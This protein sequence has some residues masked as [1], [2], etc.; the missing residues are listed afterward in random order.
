MNIWL[1]VALMGAFHGINPGMGW[2]FAVALGLQDKNSRSLFRAILPLAL[3]HA[4]ALLICLAV[5]SIGQMMIS[6][7]LIRWLAGGILI[8]FGVYRFFRQ[9]HPRWVGMRVGFRDLSV[10]SFTMALAHGAGLMLIPVFLVG[11]DHSTMHSAH[12]DT[13]MFF[14]W[15]E[16]LMGI[17]LHTAVFLC[18]TAGIAWLVYRKLGLL[19]LRKAWFNLDI[20]WAIAL[21]LSGVIAFIQ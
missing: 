3:G 11:Q 7:K 6:D 10:W 2:L 5:L 12:G 15:V 20:I 18:V 14:G 9:K 13:P 21:F 8:L 17:G 19:F 1:T 4:L 16:Y